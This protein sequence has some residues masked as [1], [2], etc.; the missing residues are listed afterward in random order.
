[1]VVFVA[2]TVVVTTVEEVTTVELVDNM[3]DADLGTD[4]VL[5]RTES[6]VPAMV[7]VGMTSSSTNESS[8]YLDGM[9]A[10]GDV[11]ALPN[12]DAID[13]TKT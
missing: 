1:M 9:H 7:V 8:V 2:A 11:G 10:P 13:A 3:V 12:D 6:S 5:S 4:V